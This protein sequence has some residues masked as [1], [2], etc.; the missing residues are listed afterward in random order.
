[1][2]DR[3]VVE[4][5]FYLSGTALYEAQT[6]FPPPIGAKV[7]FVTTT[8]KKGLPSGSLIEVRVTA[9]APPIYDFVDGEPV[10]INYSANGYDLIVEGPRPDDDD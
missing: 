3:P 1:M 6:A 4:I 10:S 8:W 7:R 5:A 2:P 9:D